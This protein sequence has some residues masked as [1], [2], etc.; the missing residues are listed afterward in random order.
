MA[1]I[2]DGDKGLLAMVQ[3]KY[4]GMVELIAKLQGESC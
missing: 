3:L 1:I 2:V 4:Y